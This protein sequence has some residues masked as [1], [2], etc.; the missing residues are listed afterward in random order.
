MSDRVPLSELPSALE[1]EEEIARRLEGRAP[2]VFLDYDGTLTPIVD[3]PA[4]AVLPEATRGAIERLSGLCTVAVI[5]GRDLRDVRRF[6]GVEGIF[7]AGSHG[8][9]IAGPN[10]ETH[11][12]GR[13][14][15]PALDRA[16]RELTP[17]LA[18]IPGSQLERKRFAI[19]I[20]FRRAED[21]RVP[22]VEAAVDRVAAGEPELRVTGGKKIF[23]LRPDIEW[24]KGR[25]LL[26]LLD[27]LELDRAQTLPFYLGDDVTDED[28]FRVLREDG[29]PIVVGDEG[30]PTLA[31][32]R[33]RDPE[34]A[35]AFLERLIVL[36]EAR[37]R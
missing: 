19:A 12:Y 8:L 1:R 21:E 23:E 13:E 2:A 34:E 26:F 28:A 18:P 15:L 9:D 14:F 36:L 10:G 29:V 20:H 22:E 37:R 4:A 7:Y 32:Y 6:V 35:R 27:A 25:A 17:L 16:E 11:Q 30:R 31:R 5:S 33:L 24:D 3:D